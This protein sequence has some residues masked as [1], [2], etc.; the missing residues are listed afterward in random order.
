MNVYGYIG[1]TIYLYMGYNLYLGLLPHPPPPRPPVTHEAPTE[2]QELNE[3]SWGVG[4]WPHSETLYKLGFPP[5]AG[6][7]QLAIRADFCC[8]TS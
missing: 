1:Y 8:G 5:D 7:E 4:P 6:F 2:E 3:T